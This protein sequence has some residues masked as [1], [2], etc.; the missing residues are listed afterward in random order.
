MDWIEQL[1][2]WD[3]DGGSGALELLILLVPALVVLTFSLRLRVH[4][5]I[6]RRRGGSDA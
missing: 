3:P 2:G 5:R 4:S 6:S 1:T